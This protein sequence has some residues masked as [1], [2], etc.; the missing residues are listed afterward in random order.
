MD[1]LLLQ[2]ISHYKKK[3]SWFCETEKVLE[4]SEC[5]MLYDKLFIQTEGERRFGCTFAREYPKMNHWTSNIKLFS[6]ALMCVT[7]LSNLI[8]KYMNLLFK[9]CFYQYN[10]LLVHK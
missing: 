4:E 6:S 10:L 1:I 3:A 7:I 5:Y 8:M 9:H 2:V